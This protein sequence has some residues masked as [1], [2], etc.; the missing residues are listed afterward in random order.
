[1]LCPTLEDFEVTHNAE[2]ERTG[3]ASSASNALL[4]LTENG[5]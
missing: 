2:I 4:G 3:V 5:D 1:M